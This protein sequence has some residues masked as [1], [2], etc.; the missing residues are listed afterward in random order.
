MY[1]ILLFENTFKYVHTSFD[2]QFCRIEN[3]IIVFQ[4]FP[5]ISC[6]STEVSRSLLIIESAGRLHFLGAIP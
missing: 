3:Y 4:V 2:P 5:V 1:I 6:I